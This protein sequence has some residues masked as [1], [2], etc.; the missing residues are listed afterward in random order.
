MPAP[1]VGLPRRD[2]AVP[3]RR[4]T[5]LHAAIDLAI[6]MA[7]VAALALPVVLSRNA[8]FGDWGNHLY[9]VDQQTRW[10]RH[11][12]L[13]TYFLHSLESGTFYPHYLFYG[14]SL[15]AA[16][17]WLG[18]L[19][20]SV[21]AYRL[22][23]VLGFAACYFGTLWAARQL[24]VRRL[25]AHVPAAIAVSGAYFVSKA[26]NDG[27]WP[28][29]IAVSMIPMVAA[30]ALSVLR[31]KRVPIIAAILLVVSTS[32]LTGSHT[33]TVVAGLLF[34]GVLV[35]IAAST[36][37]R[38]ITR[39]HAKRFWIVGALMALSVALNAWFLVPLLRYGSLTVVSRRSPQWHWHI[40]DYATRSFDSVRTVF[41]PLRTYPGSSAPGAHPFYVQAP[42]YALLWLVGVA[43]FL[44]IRRPQSKRVALFWALM[45]VLAALLTL[46]VWRGVWDDFPSFFKLIQFRYRLQ[47]YINYTVAGLVVIGLLLVAGARRFRVWVLAACLAAGAS[48]G[49]AI[50]QAWTAPTYLKIGQVVADGNRLPPIAYAN[51]PAP[52]PSV[53]HDYRIR[54]RF[55]PDALEELQVDI[56]AA[57]TGTA[58]VVLP[59]AQPYRARVVWSPVI[60]VQGPARILGATDDGWTVLQAK[61]DAK[62]TTFPLRVR[63]RP[64]TTAPVI[65]GRVISLCAATILTLW[66]IAAVVL[67]ARRR[68]ATWRNRSGS[69]GVAGGAGVGV[70]HLDGLE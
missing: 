43:V 19:I 69:E 32:L 33:L 70:E 47:A 62:H 67:R 11:H 49:L 41:S 13:P 10:L 50:W 22:T 65:A 36:S 9:L 2:G 8:F 27:G 66:L 38:S 18:V 34:L 23:F 30:S 57:R 1:A 28:E 21:N 68:R 40:F 45:A 4:P 35:A 25:V 26:F 37:R 5:A 55:D 20:G 48:L 12:L 24:G 39:A 52:C 31:S 6:G 7:V 56:P 54:G 51:C 63:I 53:E 16:T 14:G 60:E 59:T 29:F 58:E 46:V 3:R 15:Y 61:P 17:A 64:R 42:V 44:L